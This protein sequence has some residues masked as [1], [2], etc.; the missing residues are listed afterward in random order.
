MVAT[1][2]GYSSQWNPVSDH[3]YRE[4]GRA[5]EKSIRSL[6]SI[7]ISTHASILAAAAADNLIKSL[8]VYRHE[9]GQLTS[10]MDALRETYMSGPDKLKELPD[11]K[12]R[13]LN[14]DLEGY[15][16]Q[17]HL[18]SDK[19]GMILDIPRPQ[20]KPFLAFAR[21]LFKWKDTFRLEAEKN[22]IQ[23][24]FPSV[25]SDDPLRPE[26]YGDEALL[27]QLVY[28]LVS[29]AVKYCYPGTKVKMDCRKSD[30]KHESPH[31]LTVTN[32]GIEIESGTRVYELEYRGENVKGTE[33]LGIG[34][35]I[36]DQIAKAHGGEIKH[37][38]KQVSPY[39]VPLMEAYVEANSSGRNVD[40]AREISEHLEELKRSGLYS[41]V[42][43]LDEEKKLRMAEPK[44]DELEKLSSKETW[45]VTFEVTI[46]SFQE[47]L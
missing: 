30:E 35:Y 36:A 26:I 44:P 29:N 28:N 2:I 22:R 39:N 6:Y 18:L 4:C 1:W 14:T 24:S 8:R 21:L 31:V 42:V 32:Y 33:G 17:V 41:G 12:A 34:L 10:G 5:L 25:E 40:L 46:P 3:R 20:K 15:L 19:A 45:Q 11:G 7:I 27:E 37:T 9:L 23:F 43:A 16:R 13:D 38:C 47:D